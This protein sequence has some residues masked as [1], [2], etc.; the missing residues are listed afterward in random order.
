MAM[1]NLDLEIDAF[2]FPK[3]SLGSMSPSWLTTEDVPLG[4]T[5]LTTT[6]EDY[7]DV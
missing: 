6:Q 3:S 7:S 2:P 5:S 1:F 4:A